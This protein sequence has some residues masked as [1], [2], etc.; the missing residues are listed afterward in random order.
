MRGIRTRMEKVG[1]GQPAIVTERPPTDW[2][3]VNWREVNTVVKNLRRRIFRAR[4]QGNLKKVRS[5]QRLLLR[6]YSNRLVAVRRVTQVNR[7]RYTPGTDKLVVKTP[8][9]RAWLVD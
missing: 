6:S 3:A 5:L 7:G 1:A 2:N 4:R 8:E 9:R